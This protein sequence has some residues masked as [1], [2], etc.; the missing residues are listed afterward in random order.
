[1]I[2]RSILYI[3]ILILSISGISCGEDSCYTYNFINITAYE[4]KET[5]KTK[6]GITVSDYSG[7]LDLDL[8][9]KKV[10]ELENCLNMSIDYSCVSVLVPPD[11]YM[12]RCS[13][14]ELFP[15]DIDPQIC[16]DKGLIPTEECPCACRG[17]IQNDFIIVT[18]PDTVTFKGELTRLITGIN[19]PWLDSRL[20]VCI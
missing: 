15:C 7:R 20:V 13:G 18:T 11:F 17:A 8:L 14:Q 1:M 16:I 4:F 9:D 10:L 19:N 3:S 12:S 2:Y 6:L 5:A